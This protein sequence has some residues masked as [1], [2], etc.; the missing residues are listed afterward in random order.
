MLQ[1]YTLEDIPKFFEKVAGLEGYAIYTNEGL[2]FCHN[3]DEEQ[4]VERLGVRVVV[5][6]QHV[7]HDE[8]SLGHAKV[9][10]G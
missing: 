5:G 4:R 6:V 9:L 2:L 8:G 1:I 7:D 10:P 3:L